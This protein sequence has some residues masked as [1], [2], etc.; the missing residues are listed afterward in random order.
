MGLL[1]SMIY[2]SAKVLDRDRESIESLVE[3]IDNIKPDCQKRDEKLSEI[4]K[5]G[6]K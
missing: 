6:Q 3:R 1:F 2:T 5:S 4:E